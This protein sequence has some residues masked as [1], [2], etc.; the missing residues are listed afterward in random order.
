MQTEFIHDPRIKLP[1]CT[2]LHRSSDVEI[3]TSYPLFNDDPFQLGRKLVN[4]PKQITHEGFALEIDK[5]WMLDGHRAFVHDTGKLFVEKVLPADFK[6]LKNLFSTDRDTHLQWHEESGSFEYPDHLHVTPAAE[7]EGR[8]G[9]AVSVEPS[10]WGSFLC[11]VL[12]RVLAMQAEG[13][14]RYFLYCSHPRQKEMLELAG[15]DLSQI[16]PQHVGK[17]YRFESGILFSEST[18][19]LHLH[20]WARASLRQLACHLFPPTHRKRC[21][22]VSRRDGIATRSSR[23]C[24]NE[25]ELEAALEHEGFEI[26]RPDM[27]SVREQVKVFHQASL[28]VGCSGAG[29]FNT[30]FCAPGTQVITIESRPNWVYGHASL[31]SSLGLR[32]GIMWAQAENPTGPPHSPFTVDI[33]AVVSR[34]RQLQPEIYKEEECVL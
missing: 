19:Q 12:P 30:V 4:L 18:H 2:Q 17:R 14:E 20:R 24:L 6:D 10:N 22:Y 15:I 11:R 1:G 16:I 34:I 21:I 29:M 28:V 9:I 13:F 31:F 32:F 23:T 26:I 27:L 33:G 8:V 5:G 7:V 3:R 25:E